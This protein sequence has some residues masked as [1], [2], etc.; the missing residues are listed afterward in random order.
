MEI[1][2]LHLDEAGRFSK[3]FLFQNNDDSPKAK[4]SL[5]ASKEVKN[6]VVRGIPQAQ[7]QSADV[8]TASDDSVAIPAISAVPG[9]PA[10]PAIPAVEAI[11]ATPPVPAVPATPPADVP[12]TRIIDLTNEEFLKL[13]VIIEPTKLTVFKEKSAELRN[14]VSTDT[15]ELLKYGID[16]KRGTYLDK[17]VV[18]T[19]GVSIGDIVEKEEFKNIYTIGIEPRVTTIYSKKQRI[20]MWGDMAFKDTD[21]MQNA[22]KNLTNLRSVN[23]LIPLRTILKDANSTLFKVSDVV[24][25]YEATPEFIALLPDRFKNDLLKE[26][27]LAENPDTNIIAGEKYFDT[28]RTQSGAI[29][30]TSVYPNPVRDQK[31]MLD[32]SLNEDR[33]VTIILH[34]IFGRKIAELRSAQM[35][36]AGKYQWDIFLKD[37]AKGMYLISV[38]TERGEQAVQRVLVE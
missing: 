22:T 21:I 27:A 24:L 11:P 29:L 10:T 20:M 32:F 16:L 23:T 30:K 14:I 34:D 17:E 3:G 15:I 12:G 35:T 31:A 8:L 38:Q 4:R 1:P 5:K 37:V 6:T 36:A 13:G 18:Y 2:N 33:I 19:D 7:V 25:W 9:I 26:I 28:W